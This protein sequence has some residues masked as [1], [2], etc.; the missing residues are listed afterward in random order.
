MLLVYP[1]REVR[2]FCTMNLVWQKLLLSFPV[3]EQNHTRLNTSQ[4]NLTSFG[5]GPTGFLEHSLTQ[6]VYWVAHFEPETNRQSMQMTPLILPALKKVKVVSSAGNVTVSDFFRR[7]R[8]CVFW[9]IFKGATPSTE[10]NMRQ[11]LLCVSVA[12]NHPP[13]SPDLATFDNH[14]FPNMEK[15]SHFAGN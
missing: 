6:V 15:K 13:F 1:M 3:L 8:S 4:E 2:M 7:K 9:I 11:W 14:V 10:T 5:A 12:F